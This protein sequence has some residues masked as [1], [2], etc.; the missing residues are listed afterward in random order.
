[1]CV[2]DVISLKNY[3]YLKLLNTTSRYLNVLQGNDQHRALYICVSPNGGWSLALAW[4][5]SELRSLAGLWRLLSTAERAELLWAA[6][7]GFRANCQKSQLNRLI[8]QESFLGNAVQP[9]Q[10]WI[11]WLSLWD[12]S[13][14]INCRKSPVDWFKLDTQL[15]HSW[16]QMGCIL[17]TLS[18][19]KLQI[20]FDALFLRVS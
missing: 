15:S 19:T 5:R 7:K 18:V 16:H 13:L 3:R 11:R 6:V 1:M 2:I 10:K 4:V 20:V 17:A 8:E 9:I 14:S 12:T